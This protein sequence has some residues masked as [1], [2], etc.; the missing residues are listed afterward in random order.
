MK[1]AV[2]DGGRAE[3]A[4]DKAPVRRSNQLAGSTRQMKPFR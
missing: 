3:A 2:D 4:D 1:N